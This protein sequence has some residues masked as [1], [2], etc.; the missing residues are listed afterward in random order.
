M[1]PYNLVFQIEHPIQQVPAPVESIEKKVQS[2]EQPAPQTPAPEEWLS[3]K[4]VAAR[5][6]INV[7][8]VRRY[9]VDGLV[10]YHQ[11]APGKSVRIE[12]SAFLAA[13]RK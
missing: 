8:T 4:A 3:P 13:T 1:S 7:K 12:W 10:P 2:I 5:A 6:G 11:I 9:M